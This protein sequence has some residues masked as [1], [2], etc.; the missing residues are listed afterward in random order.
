MATAIQSPLAQGQAAALKVD[1]Q[2]PFLCNSKNSSAFFKE[3][4]LVHYPQVA[5][6]RESS[7]LPCEE[8]G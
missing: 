7:F 2:D 8:P 4:T 3:K 6:Q 1:L 5:Q